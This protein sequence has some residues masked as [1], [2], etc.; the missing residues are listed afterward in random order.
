MDRPGIECRWRWDSPHSSRPAVGPT[1]PP[2]ERVQGLFTNAFLMF[3]S[4]I[5]M[6]RFVLLLVILQLGWRPHV[7]SK[8]RWHTLAEFRPLNKQRLLLPGSAWILDRTKQLSSVHGIALQ[9][10]RASVWGGGGGAKAAKPSLAAKDTVLLK[11]QWMSFPE[12]NA[13]F[14]HNFSKWC[15]FFK[16]R[17]ASF[18]LMKRLWL[19]LRY[20][21]VTWCPER[22]SHKHFNLDEKQ[23]ILLILIRC[24][25]KGL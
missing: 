14:C 22:D 19:V 16:L 12:L 6:C 1:E 11:L 3:F 17:I 4:S 25:S 21:T 18:F 20:Y 13:E 24:I 5:P 7:I 9:S 8:A 23:I 10:E 15:L 2:V